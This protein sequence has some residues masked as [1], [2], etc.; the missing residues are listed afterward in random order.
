MVE[1]KKVMVVAKTVA[2]GAGAEKPAKKD[3]EVAPE[4]DAEPK[5]GAETKVKQPGGVAKRVMSLRVGSA[6]KPKG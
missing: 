1:Q 3:A 4:T 5:E 2:T 6:Q